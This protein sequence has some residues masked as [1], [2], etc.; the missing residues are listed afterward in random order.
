MNTF[1]Y[2][3]VFIVMFSVSCFAS[4]PP[5]QDNWL[6]VVSPVLT[7]LPAKDGSEIQVMD[8]IITSMTD[9]LLV[10]NVIADDTTCTGFMGNPNLNPIGDGWVL[11]YRTPKIQEG[12]DCTVKN[13]V[14]LTNKGN[15]S[16]SFN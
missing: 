9:N 3:L 14:I 2:L 10:L 13:M 7:T 8:Y 1:K 16:F 4:V 12:K 11:I 15:Q 5:K 6:L